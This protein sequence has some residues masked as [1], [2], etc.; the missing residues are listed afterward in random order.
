MAR[1]STVAVLPE[2]IVVEVNRLIRDGCTIDEILR[3]LAPL[4]VD[5]ISRSAM[6][7]YVKTARESMEKYRQGQE[8]AKVWL[9][10]LEAEPNGDVARLLPEMLRAIAFQTLSTMGESDNPV[11]PAEVMLLAKA[12]KDLGG[13]SKDN[14][15]I[16]LKMRQVRDD[17]RKALLAE[18][19]KSLQE[20]GKQD[21]VS[22]DT[23]AKIRAALGIV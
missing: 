17:A 16:E 1:K 3:A 12:L 21:G 4:G 9:D 6:G 13:A 11:K 19:A 14:V 15:A 2:E 10:R 20:V 7:R 5:N 8:V 23:M 18:Q 22:A